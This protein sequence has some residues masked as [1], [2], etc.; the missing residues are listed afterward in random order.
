MALLTPT[1]I[2]QQSTN[3]SQHAAQLTLQIT[4]F[5]PKTAPTGALT[6]IHRAAGGPQGVHQHYRDAPANE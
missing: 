2:L 6:S 5:H 4:F 1:S 3:A